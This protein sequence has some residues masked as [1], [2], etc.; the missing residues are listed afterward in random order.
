MDFDK[1]HSIER[2]EKLQEVLNDTNKK[3]EPISPPSPCNS[4]LQELQNR[5]TYRPPKPGQPETYEKI[6]SEALTLAI[7]LTMKCPQSRELS[8][9]LT[10]LDDVVF[11]A[12]AS[13]ARNT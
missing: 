2:A 6:R 11:W 8:L 4:L 5:F 10:H 12:N 3:E 7:F 1:A 13:I 9:A